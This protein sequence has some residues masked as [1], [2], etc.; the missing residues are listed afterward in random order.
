MNL[1]ERVTQLSRQDLRLLR[2]RLRKDSGSQDGARICRRDGVQPVPLSAPQE[3]LWFLDQLNAEASRA[4]HIGAT[5]RLQG[6]LDV[7]ALRAALDRIVSRHEVLRTVFRAAGEQTDQ[8][9]VA[10]TEASFSLL[11]KDL[12]GLGRDER[13]RR[14]MIEFQEEA[15]AGFDLG[16]GPLI[17]GRL[18]KQAA[19]DHVLLLRMHH[20]VC[21]GWSVGVLVKELSA[22]YAAYRLGGSEPLAALPIQYADYPAAVAEAAAARVGAARAVALLAGE[23][24]GSAGPVEPADGSGAPRPGQL[25]RRRRARGARR[26]VE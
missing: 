10:E 13:D 8:V 1:R 12:S 15:A 24:A 25:P 4:Y 18:V 5:L 19:D 17:R 20:I 3:Q 22:L 16:T 23:S 9:V 2:Q 7:A 21:D 11:E 6:E 14:L 26:E